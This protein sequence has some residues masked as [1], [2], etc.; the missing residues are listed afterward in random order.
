VRRLQALRAAGLAAVIALRASA[1][2]TQTPSPSSSPSPS[3]LPSPEPSPQAPEPFQLHGE[4]KLDGRH[5]R[6]VQTRT[7]T[8][9]GPN[10][11][12]FVPTG[13]QRTADAGGALELQNVAL[14]GQGDLGLG[15]S[16]KVE[17]H[18]LDLYNRNP[19]SSDDRIF[20]REAWLRFG[21]KADTLSATGDGP[22]YVLAGMAPRFSKPTVRALESYGMWATAVGRFEMPQ[23]QIG[24]R[25]GGPVYWRAQV[26]KGNPL[27]YRDTNVLAGDNG[28]IGPG[29]S[30]D[31]KAYETGFPIFYDAK[32]DDLDTHG[33]VEWGLGLGLRRV[34]ARDG[35]AGRTTGVDLLGWY[36]RRRLADKVPLRGTTE[37]GDLEL[38]RGRG[39]PLPFSGRD[40]WEAGLNV[41]LRH[42]RWRLDGQLVRQ[43]IAGLERDGFDAELGAVLSLPGLFLVGETPVGNWIRPVLRVSIIANDFDAPLEYPSLSVD[44]DWRKYD[45]GLRFGLVRDVDL[46]VEYSRHDMIVPTV[47]KLHPDEFLVTLRMGL[48][49]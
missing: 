24:G 14:V 42:G 47:G 4:V 30:S 22:F 49:P 35:D 43:S 17:L 40:K 5:S 21:R 31:A 27:Y 11:I 16:A 41:A 44:W 29:T 38:L 33:Q 15:V 28:A 32:A 19:T 25:V 36:F 2:G 7:F 1:A 37:F 45:L 23:V 48:R 9:R 8:P 26:G 10:P 39:F 18:V 6:F 3:P 20:V 13:F 46:T 34:R 12:R